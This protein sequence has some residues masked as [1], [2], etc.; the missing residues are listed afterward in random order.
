MSLIAVY[1]T[2]NEIL[3]VKDSETERYPAVGMPS[4]DM[5]LDEA[6][7]HWGYVRISGWVPDGHMKSAVVRKVGT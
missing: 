7:A 1:N 6:L 5:D 4:A 3:A 2:Y